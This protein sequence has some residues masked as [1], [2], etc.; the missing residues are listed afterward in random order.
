M[1][2]QLNVNLGFSAD[3]S[4]A[5]RQLQELQTQLKNLVTSVN[6]N[7][8]N[9][10]LTDNIKEA[11]VAATQLQVQL[12]SAVNV[13]TGRLDLGKFSQS[14]KKSG[15]SIEQY[16]NSLH[17]LGP[18]GD[19]AFASLAKSIMQAEIPLRRS[20]A[21]VSEMWTSLKNTARWQISSSVLHGFM[22]AVQSAYGYAQD[23]NESL[24]NIRIVT[25][26][27]KNEM[28]EFA[29]RANRAAKAL[30]TTTTDYTNA[31][32]IYYQQ[33][34]NNSEV[35]ERT[36]ITMKMANV[37]GQSAETVSEQL[38]AVWNNFYDGSKSLE[39]YADVMTALGAA[40]ASS[41]DEIAG[42]LEKFAAIG[43][44]IGLSYEYAASALAT[45]TSNT[46]QSEEVVGTALKTIFAR[47]QGLELGETLDDGVTLNKYSEALSA[48]GIS[49][50]DSA[51][52]LKNMDNILDEMAN[53]WDTMSKAQQTALA[54]TV[55]GVRQYT[56]LVALMEN[57][58][59]GD[60]DSMAAN[61]LTSKNAEGAV[62]VQ[63]DIYAQSWEAAQKRV[64]ASAESIYS[65]L[66]NDEFFI[67]LN[68][69]LAG[70]LEG[71]G[72]IMDGMGGLKGILLMVGS[73]ALTVFR[74][75]ISQSVQNVVYSIKMLTNK[76]K[77]E[78]RQLRDQ[79]NKAL[80]NGS[81]GEAETIPEK[82]RAEAYADL[83]RLQNAYLK[84]VSRMNQE[85]K[86]IA[87]HLMDQQQILIKNVELASEE[88]SQREEELNLL[89]RKTFKKAESKGTISREDGKTETVTL[90]GVK[91]QISDYKNLQI[92]IG[93]Y[94]KSLE[95][96]GKIKLNN[97]N[98]EEQRK[99]LQAW[100]N[101]INS[102][103][104]NIKKLFGENAKKAFDNFSKG[105]NDSSKSAEELNVLIDSLFSSID[106]TGKEGEDDFE[107]IKVALVALGISAE[108]AEQRLQKLRQGANDTG[109]SFADLG[110]KTTLLSSYTDQISQNFEKLHATTS[111][112]DK[113]MAVASSIGNV[114]SIVNT[115]KSTMEALNDSD[116][117]FGEKIMAVMSG[118]SM[119]LPSVIALLDTQNLA[120][121]KSAGMW[122]L[123]AGAKKLSAGSSVIA[124]GAT[125]LLE[126]IKNKESIAVAANSVAWYANP[127]MWIA[128]I[129]I[130]VV[131]A[132]A[133]LVAVIAILT[134]KLIKGDKISTKYCDTL[135]ETAEKTKEL[136]EAN[137]EL[138]NSMDDLIDE[139]DELN[140]KGENTADVLS[141][142][143]EQM[144][145]LIQSYKDF[146]EAVEVK[147]LDENIA[148]L[149][150][151]ANL[152][153]FTGDYSKFEEQKQ[154]VDD[155]VSKATAEAAKTGAVNA[156]TKLAASMQDTQ[157]KV[158]GTS[159]K[160]H[161][162]GSERGGAERDEQEAIDILEK[163]MGSFAKNK[164]SNGRGIDLKIDDYTDPLQMVEYYEKM[165]AARD[166]ML[167]EMDD[168][169]L[170][171]SDTFREINEMI[172]ATAEAYQEA[173]EQADEYA[174]T[175]GDALSAEMRD[176][177]LLKD[178][179]ISGD[180]D[181]ME[182]YLSYKQKYI[183]I[184]KE[185]YSL[186]EEQAM[187]QLK[188]VEGLE[189]LNSEY[190]LASTMLTK[191]SGISEGQMKWLEILDPSVIE[192]MTDGIA[193]E[194]SN[195]LG[196]L[197]EED[198][199]LA[200]SIAADSDSIED[201]Y[202]QMQIAMVETARAGYSQ[203]ANIA[204]E[205]LNNS[206]ESGSISLGALLDDDNFLEHL[207]EIGTSAT[208]ITQ[209]SY[210]EQYRIIS[211][212]YS[213]VSTSAFESFEVQQDLLYQQLTD[214]QAELSAYNE[215]VSNG[216]GEA[217]AKA[218]AEYQELKDELADTNNP[219][220]IERLN[221]T[222]DELRTKFEDTYHFDIESNAVELENEL[223]TIL[224]KIQELQD[225]KIEMAMD[226]SDVDEVANGYKRAA[227]FTQMIEKDT[228]KVGNSYQMT[229]TQAREWLE[230]YPEL[231]EIAQVTTDGLISMN[232]DEVDAFIAGK[233]DELDKSVDVKIKEL[234]AQK[235]VLESDLETKKIELEAAEKLAQGKLDLEDVSAQYLVELRGNLTDYFIGLG[236]DETAANA[237]ALETMGMNEEEYSRAVA[238]SC[239][240]QADNMEGA[241]EDGANA[242]VSALGQLVARWANFGRY[243]IENIGPILLEI[244]KAILD[245]TKTV[246][247]VIK[248]AW[249]ASAI[250]VNADGTHEYKSN[251]GSYTFNSG[252]ETQR[253]AAFKDV[254]SKQTDSVK[255]S[256]EELE[257]AIG[258]IDGK[259][260]YL[261]SLGTAGLD[262]YGSTDPTEN[263][264]K[265]GD[266]KKK[267]TEKLI[268]EAERYHEI[269][270]EVETLEHEL[271]LLGMQKDK[272]F[273]KNKL[274]LMDQEI[275]KYEELADKQ[276]SLANSQKV[277]LALDRSKA[278]DIGATFDEKGNIS[279]YTDLVADI[280]KDYNQ[281]KET[282]NKSDQE[283]SDKDVL[284][285][286][287]EE[288]NKKL[289]LLEQYEETLDA[290]RESEKTALE[291]H[292]AWQAANFEK[293]SYSL[294]IK[295]EVDEAKLNMID[296]YLKKMDG[297]V[298]SM[299]E[300]L[301]KIS[302]EQSIILVNQANDYQ[303]QYKDLQEA[304]SNGKISEEDYM[305]SIN[306]LQEKMLD[307]A[308][309]L[310]ELDQ[311]TMNYYG[312]TLQAAQAEIDKYT[313]RMDHLNGVLEHY[314]TIADLSTLH[315]KSADYFKKMDTVLEGQAHTAKNS[316]E[317]AKATMTMFQ[318]EL[319]AKQQAYETALKG[320]DQELIKFHK[321]QYEDA[322]SAANAA[323]EEYLSRVE[324][325]AEKVNQILEHTL[326][327]LAVELE[328]ALT[329]GTSFDRMNTGMER[330]L[331]LHE[332]YLTTTNKIYET[333]KL[334]RK[335]QQ[336][337]D[338]TSNTVAKNKMKQ[339]I[340][341]TQNL[342][343]QTK[344]SK[345]ELEIQQAKY[346]LLVAEIALEEAK[347]AKS[348][349]RLQRD[350]EGNFGYIY[351][352]DQEIVANAEQDFL[353]AQNSLYNIGLEGAN[354]Y[355]QKY[356]QTM[357]EMYDTLTSLA[358]QY[359]DG[360]FASEAE[361]QAAVDE[362]K[363]FYYEKLDQYSYLHSK[364]IQTDSRVATDYILSESNLARTS[365]TGDTLTV[366]DT[367]RN[368]FLKM[369]GW[370]T[371]EFGNIAGVA[372]DWRDEVESY[373][374]DVNEAFGEWGTT[375]STNVTPAVGDLDEN[376][377]NL[378]GASDD[379]LTT[380][381]GENGVISKLQEEILEVSNLTLEY[382]GLRQAILDAIAAAE[383]TAATI[384][385]EY[386]EAAGDEGDEEIHDGDDDGDD[387]G[388]GGGGG[389]SGGGN[390]GSGGGN[391]GSGGGGSGDGDF[392]ADKIEGV[393]A[394]IWM[395]GSK[396]GWGNDPERA[397]KLKEKGVSGA[398]DYIN[399][400]AYNG[401]I[402]ANWADKRQQLKKYYYGSFDTGGYTG[403]WSGP[404]GKFAMLH[405]KELV[406]NQQDTENFLASMEVLEKI[407]QVIDLQSANQLL[408]KNMISPSFGNIGESA[409]EQ[410]VHIEASF[411]NATDKNEIEEA[412]KDLVNL[413]SQYVN[414][415]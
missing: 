410:N 118:I 147:G 210:E 99:N 173:K 294:E 353:D 49:I 164:N 338:K 316:M 57:W 293:L 69:G 67:D 152:A 10:V 148:K 119:I 53:R 162:G 317:A 345:F 59:N 66:L 243:L 29:E 384:I 111:V 393:A 186:T 209:M 44:T 412:F 133:A 408:S 277:F 239:E 310:Q 380:L 296:Y 120:L 226:W 229:A 185:E 363:Q 97:K 327:K 399:E 104:I 202:N 303:N 129:V 232:A 94:K 50:F 74:D 406:L 109:E 116:L 151:L 295:V 71:L 259:I 325:Y 223:D 65:A 203:S 175:V 373:V 80:I 301:A 62:S 308:A 348:T 172:G 329:G 285:Q 273:G 32:L 354:N 52:E 168:D 171:E 212:F 216:S 149:E 131:A 89:E 195:M 196:E 365:I 36:N 105:I 84:N 315:K 83:G 82:A 392:N 337:M 41:A 208:A 19:Q 26:Q 385:D 262:D 339:F 358:Q 100:S 31:S 366:G 297:D 218:Q 414:R 117:S 352:A 357:A 176:S 205:V 328:D 298:Y 115:F 6:T 270:K 409:L 124:T 224:D 25:G 73:V 142:I 242:Q 106:S 145:N 368:T 241:A 378:K 43:D 249:D 347:N 324:A 206:V 3:T 219:F 371:D 248:D 389:G 39:Y 290:V 313:E 265:T 159:Y 137:D 233:D 136:A 388:S 165:V 194:V 260:A 268:E 132:I 189:R 370:S 403:D 247:G 12:E 174:A 230:F 127:I 413:A 240:N 362:A 400:S 37:S 283:D 394:A 383:S 130:G 284:E 361:Y 334:S 250:T 359:R 397:R 258:S 288:Y 114:V 2:K 77:E 228:K 17:Q 27:N 280:T 320:T 46:R 192:H 266:D 103:G 272:A 138:S 40:T 246:S 275:A 177:N 8:S 91:Q 199:A 154:V 24:N 190:E 376:V 170:A 113:F 51:G 222:L 22:G 253:T 48:V 68:N 45:I 96:I 398:Q 35:E 355:V 54:Q 346:D 179:N 15:M 13:N 235:A 125:K 135:I 360:E 381:T 93:Q 255:A 269:T 85:Q 351:T 344:L 184:A 411:P 143:A 267:N 281:A 5:K 336:E 101:Q 4:Q 238:E 88:A 20:N 160:L 343:N 257:G 155:Q 123:E 141:R 126:A 251:D 254:A 326:N 333:N 322:L 60:N 213:K 391:G 321:K 178:L 302:K 292:Q 375:M 374:E 340:Q 305:K 204:K 350:S 30:S 58:D 47:I 158:S 349:V 236:L 300:S 331:S 56:Q 306:E 75:Q 214:I 377:R 323:E 407:V 197:S 38:T 311:Q 161:V 215:A 401:T 261:N 157:G 144:P 166:R 289:Q 342:Q 415:K 183:E 220:E 356:Q 153:K 200:I 201:F 225:Q 102:S 245:P 64:T 122:I 402:Y 181:T 387:D 396:S 304:F 332:E 33:G 86:E 264:S 87:Q 108:D 299:G 55:A 244:G 341:E 252:D 61:L 263:D 163:E 367:W 1:A 282:Y 221:K 276:A 16:K 146:A 134:E 90:E 128:V 364:A 76:G 369:S 271:E 187:A 110:Q 169:Q 23:L 180:V 21:L 237:A 28:A 319:T 121:M 291:A 256:I 234:E 274:A 167:K 72:K 395:D 63:A 207:E 78:V 211:E 227:Q 405:Q 231:G 382:Q 278:E 81:D 198:L 182:E 312:Q 279:N 372:S 404:D 7:K 112:G 217:I 18:A 98:F 9:F 335:A 386:A 70:F 150:R 95:Q 140:E 11:T 92:Q 286:A 314:G 14:L 34:L 188:Q 79:A 191:F 107:K 307:N 379:L 318:S 156:N 330:M 193:T 309:A 390:G 42:G 139:Y 287:E